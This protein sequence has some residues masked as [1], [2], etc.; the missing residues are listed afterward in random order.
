MRLLVLSEA[1]P[2]AERP[3]L[4][5]VHTRNLSYVKAG[6]TPVVC[7]F[8]ARQPYR[9]DG[10]EVIDPA[11]AVERLRAESVD[12][13][14]A[15]A[16][17]LRHHIRWMH[18]HRSSWQRAL[19]FFHGHECLRTRAYYP[20]P[21]PGMGGRRQQVLQAAYDEVKLPVLT[22]FLR[23]WLAEGRCDLVFVSNWFHAEFEKAV[24]LDRRLLDGHS[25]VIPN[26]INPGIL[27]GRH[28]PAA[29]RATAATIRQFDEPKYGIDVTIEIA[30][31][32]PGAAVHVL[33]KGRYLTVH[34]PP[35]NVQLAGG[36]AAP[37]DL[38]ATLDRYS[39]A[40]L[41]TRFDTQGVLACEVAAYGMPLV[42]SDIAICR[43]V[44]EGFDGVHLVDN[45][46]PEVDLLA[47]AAAGVDQEHNRALALRRF[48]PQV[49]TDR[50]IQLLRAAI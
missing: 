37:R 48:G 1:Y 17:N 32:N 35:P 6:V 8:E 27:A 36:F 43:E 2:T 18:A 30:R 9:F 41:P 42:T 34:P 3:A 11:T 4:V 28:D 26:G 5:Y 29:P 14:A 40:V 33:G 39:C 44:L 13:I 50:E 24:K 22:F 45:D 12:V 38:P 47:I 16:P 49:T 10:I 23:R 25:H 19:L 46:D 21:F 15:H 31:R 20:P 7:C